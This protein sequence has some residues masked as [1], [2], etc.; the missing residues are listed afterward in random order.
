MSGVAVIRSLLAEAVAVTAVV[1]AA[2]I[3]AGVLPLATALPALGVSQV[4]GAER[5]TVSMAEM[6][7]LQTE[8]VQV[9]VHAVSYAQ[10]K[11]LVGLVR[12]ACR[13]RA[14][15]VGGTDLDSI[16]PGGEGPDGFE[17]DPAIYQQ[18]IDFLVRWRSS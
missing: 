11:Q 10:Q 4:S 14:G 5:S 13:N 2:R 9:M 1:P 15:L 8:R 7:K 17:P 3:A 16:L 12:R 18:T 6:T